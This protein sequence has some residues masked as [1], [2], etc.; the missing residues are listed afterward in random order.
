MHD[1]SSAQRDSVK[2][3]LLRPTL[4]PQIAS[5]THTAR[6]AEVHRLFPLVRYRDL[7]DRG[8]FALSCGLSVIAPLFFAWDFLTVPPP[9]HLLP[10]LRSSCLYYLFSLQQLYLSPS[11][12]THVLSPRRRHHCSHLSKQHPSNQQPARFQPSIFC[13]RLHHT[14]T[15]SR[16]LRINLWPACRPSIRHTSPRS[17]HQQANLHPRS[18]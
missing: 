9:R 1:V 6:R 12:F 15:P 4:S 11:D 5:T 13:S 7:Q 3:L 10:L 2:A 14:T 8:G 18:R 16:C 17:R